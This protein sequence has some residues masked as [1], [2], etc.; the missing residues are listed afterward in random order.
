MPEAANDRGNPTI[1]SISPKLKAFSDW[2]LKIMASGKIEAIF[3]ASTREY[4]P[5]VENLWNDAAVKATYNRRNELQMLPN[6]ASYFLEQVLIF[7]ICFSSV[8][9]I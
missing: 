7:E 9:N 4:A 1:Y 3:P 8:L 2:L 6:S 5:I